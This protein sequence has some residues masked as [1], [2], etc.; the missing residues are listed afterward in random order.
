MRKIVINTCFG[1]FGISQEAENLMISYG[2]DP[3]KGYSRD[4]E[5]L[6]RVVEELGKQ[7]NCWFSDLKIVQIPD[8]VKWQIEEYDGN[9]WVAEKHRTW[10]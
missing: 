5:V 2:V 6:V 4:N 8:K 7:A 1:G 9:E 10:R 3:K